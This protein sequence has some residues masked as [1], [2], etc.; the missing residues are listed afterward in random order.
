MFN[1]TRE[2]YGSMMNL[3]GLDLSCLPHCHRYYPLRAP[4]VHQDQAQEIQTPS[5]EK[6]SDNPWWSWDPE[7]WGGGGFYILVYLQ[8]PR[9]QWEK[10]KI[11]FYTPHFTLPTNSP[12]THQPLIPY[13]LGR[14][15]ISLIFSQI[16]W[17]GRVVKLMTEIEEWSYLALFG[18]RRNGGD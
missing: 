12:P 5:V 4:L 3:P 11:D 15:S 8:A 18:L 13:I 14:R 6:F 9:C 1:L 17:I 2:S 10:E 7:G 16:F